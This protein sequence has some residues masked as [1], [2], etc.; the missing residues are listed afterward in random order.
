MGAVG[1]GPGPAVT[2]RPGRDPVGAVGPGRDPAV[3]LDPDPDPTVTADPDPDPAVDE[4][5]LGRVFLGRVIEPGD[6]VGGRWV[7]E[8]GVGETVRR[9]RDGGRALPGV[10]KVRWAGLVVRG[11]RAEPERDLAQARAAGARF[12]APGTPE[13]PRQ[14]DD[15]ADARP[16]GLWVRGRPSLRMWALRSVAVVGARACTEYGTHVAGTLAAGLAERGWVVVSGGAYGID[17]AAHRGALAAGGATVAVLA[18]GVDRPYPR[19]HTHLIE[20]IA[21]QGL[22]IGELP[23]GDHPTPSRFI[24]RNRVI[25]SSVGVTAAARHRSQRLC[26]SASA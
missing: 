25:F 21:Q 2:V 22:V 8:F 9:V 18:G 26:S 5:T 19:G 11:A 7:R 24:L 12:V 20:R 15:L 3:T 14:L 1:P 23:P 16:L 4:D 6:E 13:W 17:A 10:S